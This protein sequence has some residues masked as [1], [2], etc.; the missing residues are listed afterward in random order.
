MTRRWKEGCAPMDDS[1]N[2]DVSSTFTLTVFLDASN[3][4]VLQMFNYGKSMKDGSD[5]CI[6][7]LDRED[8]IRGNRAEI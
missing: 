2:E 6:I 5:M 8:K 4:L 1:Q 7:F 3:V